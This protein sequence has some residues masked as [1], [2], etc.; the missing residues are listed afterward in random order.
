[1]RQVVDGRAVYE[2][3]TL[4]EWVPRIVAD[5]V[6]EFQPVKIIL[7]GSVARGDDG[8]DSDIDLLVVLPEVDPA[9]RHELMTAMRHA[10]SV[11][12]SIDTY[13]TDPREVERRRN[14]IG[15]RHYWPLREGKVVYERAA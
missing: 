15:S 11:P 7:Y 9:R 4:A 13:P 5:L 10:I 1:M 3:K 12:L 6:A 14:V 8:P 2:G